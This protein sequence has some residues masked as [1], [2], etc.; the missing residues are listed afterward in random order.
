MPSARKIHRQNTAVNRK[1]ANQKL[2]PVLPD[3]LGSWSD[4]SGE[5]DSTLNE[6]EDLLD[7]DE[8]RPYTFQVHNGHNTSGERMLTHVFPSLARRAGVG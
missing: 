2:L 8:S 1:L 3:E 4:S 6:E 7:L 5:S